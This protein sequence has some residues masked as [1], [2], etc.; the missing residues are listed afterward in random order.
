VNQIKIVDSQ[1][2]PRQIWIRF[3]RGY[4]AENNDW[5]DFQTHRKALGLISV[6]QCNSQEEFN[7][8]CRIHESLKVGYAFTLF[9]SRCILFGLNSD[10]TLY[11]GSHSSDVSP[12]VDPTDPDDELHHH[13]H[14][15][16]NK[17]GR[18]GG[19][20]GEGGSDTGKQS[21][22]GVSSAEPNNG[23]DS[24]RSVDGVSVASSTPSSAGELSKKL[25]SSD[26]LR[27]YLGGGGGG[28]V[29]ESEATDSTTSE[30]SSSRSDT[31]SASGGIPY[32]SM[33]ES[34]NPVLGLPPAETES[35][36]SGHSSEGNKSLI[37]PTNFKARTLFYPMMD[38][39]QSLETDIEEFISSLFWVLE[40]KRL[41]K[42]A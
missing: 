14:Y 25:P 4:P 35:L 10:G 7:E 28:S 42:L 2:H 11:E 9:D 19:G 13:H 6:G 16:S 12:C 39:S 23:S 24:F 30:D 20:G 26:S 3:L 37:A 17:S 15:S 34:E 40:S 22:S 18:S 29:E 36:K 1:G 32:S 27:N 5:G 8:L 21:S 33:R 38:Q 41:D 31:N